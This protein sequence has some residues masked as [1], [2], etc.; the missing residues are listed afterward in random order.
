MDRPPPAAGFDSTFAFARDPYRFISTSC[1]R[2]KSDI[3]TT[4]LLLSP[5]ICVTGREAAALFYGSDRVIRAGAAPAA[6]Q[7][8]L[9]GSGGVQGLDDAAHRRR[10]A[11]F[12]DITRDERVRMLVAITRERWLRRLES[13]LQRGR[14]DTYAEFKDLLFEAV[15]VWA[16]V[17]VALHEHATRRDEVASLFEHAGSLGPRHWLA[18]AARHR[19]ERWAADLIRAV[20]EDRLQPEPESALARIAAYREAD[21]REPTAE[22]AAV[23]LLNV[24]R[25]T[26]AV[27]V[28][29]VLTVHALET[30]AAAREAAADVSGIDAVVQEVRRFYPFFPAAI[31]RVRGTGDWAG[32]TLVKDRR[33]I[34]DLYGINHDPR[35]WPEPDAFV[36]QRF[37]GRTPDAFA[38]IPQ[39]GGW[40]DRSHRCPG[41]G[42][43]VGLMT[44]AVSM[45]T[46]HLTYRVPVQDLRLDFGRLPALPRSGL[47]IE[48]LR[49]P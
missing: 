41:E 1:T 27:A 25:P 31:G 4:R 8:T 14:I 21:G 3:F 23:E 30:Q 37:I 22:R 49:S 36:P 20:R 34:L 9:T 39:G 17:P 16:G 11:L 12:L 7:R 42:I 10:K 28:Y 35:L 33:I 19:S 44:L 48:V 5:V 32:Y 2:L 43:A 29:L 24:I 6:V 15:C 40:A 26:V 18:R 13:W 47:I 46:R 45:F 38:F